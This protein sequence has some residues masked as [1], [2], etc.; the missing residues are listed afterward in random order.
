METGT[1]WGDTDGIIR[2]RSELRLRTYVYSR[3]SSHGRSATLSSP[4]G[5]R[6]SEIPVLLRPTKGGA[7]SGSTPVSIFL[8]EGSG[9]IDAVANGVLTRLVLVD[10][11]WVYLRDRDLPVTY[12]SRTRRPFSLEILT[13]RRKQVP[14]CPGMSSVSGGGGL[15]PLT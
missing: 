14:P 8:R 13:P 3:P 11:L 12:T 10:R 4:A 7:V 6:T 2:S 1:P 15:S 9:G 5:P